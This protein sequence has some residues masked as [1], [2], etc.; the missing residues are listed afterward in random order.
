VKTHIRLGR[1]TDEIISLAK[2]EEISLVLM[3][4][5]GKGFLTGLIVGSTTLG[6]AI[7]MNRPLMVIRSPVMRKE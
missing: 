3:S 4:S 2:A 1:P 7:H 5:H 6:V